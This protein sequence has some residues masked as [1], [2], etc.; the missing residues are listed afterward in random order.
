MFILDT[1]ALFSI[2][3]PR[4]VDLL[5]LDFDRTFHGRQAVGGGGIG[6]TAMYYEEEARLSFDHTDD[7]R[8]HYILPVNVAL[9]TQANAEYPS[10]LGM[11]FI[12][13][14]RLTVD[15]NN[16]LIELQ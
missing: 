8:T 12:S 13:N 14:F 1:G 3:H 7:T 10:I 4:D 11:D 15:F 16:D 5:D 6:G 2:L 9:P